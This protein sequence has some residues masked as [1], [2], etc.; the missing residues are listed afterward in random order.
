MMF[1]PATVASDRLNVFA[2]AAVAAF[3]AG[4]ERLCA[5][6]PAA[7]ISAK[8]MPQSGETVATVTQRSWR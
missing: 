7:P 4:H 2:S 8:A 3:L 1:T 5:E 6:R